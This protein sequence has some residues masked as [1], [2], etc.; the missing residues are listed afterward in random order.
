MLSLMTATSNHK[1]YRITSSCRSP[2]S[3]IIIPSPLRSRSSSTPAQRR[4][5]V[6][7]LRTGRSARRLVVGV[8]GC[9]DVARKEIQALLD[10]S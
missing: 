7:E 10:L 5:H 8:V 9:Q 1:T 2:T 4:V 6:A 3:L